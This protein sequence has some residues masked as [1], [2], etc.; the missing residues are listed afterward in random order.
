MLRK[1]GDVGYDWVRVDEL[2][3]RLGI[4]LSLEELNV[5]QSSGAFD[6]IYSVIDDS[7]YIRR[8]RA[9][10]R[11]GKGIQ[12]IVNE[13][14]GVFKEP[15][16]KPEFTAWLSKVAPNDWVSIY[17]RLLSDGVVEEVLVSGMVFIKVNA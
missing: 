13:L 8:R 17:E 10:D 15:V 5:L 14:R 11:N 2:E 1:L 4:R 3:E 12:D 6:V 7:F 9:R 16:P